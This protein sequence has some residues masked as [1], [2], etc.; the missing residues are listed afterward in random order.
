VGP[1]REHEQRMNGAI[2]QAVERRCAR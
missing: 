1:D 2:K